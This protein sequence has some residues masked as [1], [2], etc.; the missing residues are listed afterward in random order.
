MTVDVIAESK[1]LVL[2]PQFRLRQEIKD[3]ICRGRGRERREKRKSNANSFLRSHRPNGDKNS[4]TL[5]EY[6]DFKGVGIFFLTIIVLKKKPPSHR[7]NGII[8]M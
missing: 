6:H 2:F 3:E 4:I 5:S 8:R 7:N 1:F